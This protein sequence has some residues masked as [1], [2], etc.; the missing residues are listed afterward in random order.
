VIVKKND[1]SN[2][3]KPHQACSRSGTSTIVLIEISNYSEIMRNAPCE[4]RL[5]MPE[6]LN[7]TFNVVAGE[8]GQSDKLASAKALELLHHES[9]KELLSS[10]SAQK[11]AA[12][13]A[14]KTHGDSHSK[15][16]LQTWINAGTSKVI[17]NEETRNTVNRL[18]VDFVKTAS[19]F[20]GGKLGLTSTFVAYGLD[21]ARPGDSWKAQAADFALGG[22][23]G[24]TMKGMFSVIG[25]SGAIAPLKGA[26]MGLSSGAVDEVFKRETFIDP[27]SLNDRLRRNAFNPQAILMNAAVFTA[28]EG[29]YSGISLS[30]R[31][32]LAENRMLSGMV[33][34]GSFGFVNGSVGEA[35]R[36]FAENGRI[37][38]GKVLLRGALD[39]SVSAVGAG[40]GMKVSDPVFQQKVKDSA[41]N[42]LDSVGL[43]P[44]P[45]SREFVV[46]GGQDQ[47]QNFEDAKTLSALTTVREIRNILGWERVGPEK[48]LLIQHSDAKAGS[49]PIPQLSDLLASCNP[50]ELGLAER[51]ASLFPKGK[52]PVY[53]EPGKE[54]HIR[55]TLGDQAP[56]W[57]NGTGGN[58]IMLGSPETKINAMAPLMIGDPNN[59]DGQA[60][61][62][63]W[64]EF[65]RQLSLG[66]KAGLDGISTDVWWGVVEPKEGQFSWNYYDK[67]SS[68][69][70]GS[71]LKWVPILSF[72]ECGGNVGDT[73]NVP[74]PFWVWNKISGQIPG[75]GPD[76]GKFRSEQGN[77]SSE[78]PQFWADKYAN[79]LYKNVMTAF[80]DHFA[81]KA[82]GMGEINIS[83]GPAG[84]ARYPS[85]N[86]H[87]QN[88]NYPTRGA[89]QCYS[90]LAK[91]DF[92][93]WV[94]KKYGNFENV[95]R[96]WG[97]HVENIEPPVDANGFFNNNIHHNTQ[98]GRD[99]FDWYNGTLINHIQT[100]MGTALD[101]YGTN[102]VYKNVDIGMKL[103]GIHWRVGN[104]D[105]GNL[106]MGDRLAE[107][108]AGMITT[109]HN[110][111][112]S[113]D[114]GRGYR[115]LLSGIKQ[116]MTKPGGDRL[117][118]HFTA[119]EMSDGIDRNMG[120]NAMPYTLANWVGQEAQRQGLSIKGENAL[121]G[122]LANENA[123]NNMASHL[124]LPG[125][126]GYYQGLTLLRL[127]DV[128]G[129]DAARRNIELLT[130]RTKAG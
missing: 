84:E 33:M 6:I 59:P 130:T 42:A 8:G 89:L 102:P 63:A 67:M 112:G 111:W 22:A 86:H 13:P 120:A 96:A 90:E 10:L 105:G 7:N 12:P 104:W 50:E 113:D 43:S 68:Q 18:T 69:I 17:S 41:L 126:P 25:S 72:H 108:D 93:N 15:S 82:Q 48:A 9:S 76:V 81:S 94:M 47:L 79:P 14:D 26:L 83:L 128:L 125:Q 101:V 21:Q 28:G 110:D 95:N 75:S 11:L 54:N 39:A 3:V 29:L 49:V 30:T 38:P 4:P 115:P 64:D 66:K 24:E 71:G 117:M 73:V 31:G 99:F 57:K 121:G 62:Q 52:G 51:A 35:S 87:D 70:I 32:A 114:A 91:A 124:R 55:L 80:A 1:E 34:G 78:Y 119:L 23:K 53:L 27:A 45:R 37:N 127:S 77:V 60:S 85:Y 44:Y 107:L 88:V 100:V 103:P 19:L 74:V 46:T 129:S 16:Y 56:Q 40:V 109:S 5:T 36:E 122:N 58:R 118:L 2:A 106:N 61:K 92:Q 116:L 20:T 97:G 123:W 65:A 98:Y